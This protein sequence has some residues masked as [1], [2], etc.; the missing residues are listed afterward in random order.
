MLTAADRIC[1]EVDDGDASILCK[2]EAG[3]TETSTDSGVDLV[4]DTYVTLSIRVTGT[5]IVQFFVEHKLVATHT[6]NI[7]VTELAV[8]AMSLS[9]SAT[10]TRRTRID[11]LFAAATR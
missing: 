2:T 4:D 7:P 1:F 9:G 11:Y 3:G 5:G 8:A 6:T 10:G